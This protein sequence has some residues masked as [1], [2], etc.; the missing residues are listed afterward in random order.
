MRTHVGGVRP[1]GVPF[2]DVM[3]KNLGSSHADDAPMS[4]LRSICFVVNFAS[5]ASS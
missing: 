2:E 5:L 3:L 4:P 1:N